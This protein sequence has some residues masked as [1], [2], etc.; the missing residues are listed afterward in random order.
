M[1]TVEELRAAA[2]GLSAQR[3]VTPPVEGTIPPAVD[4]AAQKRANLGQA[5]RATAQGLGSVAGAAVG[6][7][8]GPIGMAGFGALGAMAGDQVANITLRALKDAGWDAGNVPDRLTEDLHSNYNA[9]VGD[10]L[11]SAA[12]PVVSLALRGGARAGRVMLGVNKESMELAKRLSEVGVDMS[13]AELSSSKLMA[14]TSKVLGRFPFLMPYNRISSNRVMGE[15]SKAWDTQ[16]ANIAPIFGEAQVGANLMMAAKRNYGLVHTAVGKAYKKAFEAGRASGAVMD[17]KE[18][19]DA[20][21]GV[22]KDMSL[23]YPNFADLPAEHDAKRVLKFIETRIAN[24]P[25]QI[26][27][28]HWDGLGIDFRSTMKDVID[29]KAQTWIINMAEARSNL[30]ATLNDTNTAILLAEADKKFHSM[31]SIFRGTTA[32]DFNKVAKNVFRPGLTTPNHRYVEET[33][34][35]VFD[36]ENPSAIKELRAMAGDMPFRMAVVSHLDKVFEKNLTP[37][38]GKLNVQGFFSELGLDNPKSVRYAALEEMLSSTG[39]KVQTVKD[40]AEAVSRV[41]DTYPGEVNTFIARRATMGGMAGITNALLPTSA[42]AGS[43]GG[44]GAKF[45]GP[46]VGA[47]AIRNFSYIATRPG[48]IKAANT[49]LDDTAGYAARRAATAVLAHALDVGGKI[50]S[51]VQDAT[52]NLGG[53]N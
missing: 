40:L 3:E 11:G 32:K 53:G 10:L 12:A 24:L 47:M 43:V 25:P 38:K 48:L 30:P 29:D 9:A 51:L 27:L 45:I 15:V 18:L 14:F 39:V 49:A 23:K 34:N 46:L 41:V 2:A 22:L 1:P 19:V 13:P 7:P 4:E 6:A 20:A 36:A 16:L 52:Q 8:A 37:G 17:T 21:Q 26:S 44:A 50:D 35:T 42:Y 5:L 28:D 31:V 33:L